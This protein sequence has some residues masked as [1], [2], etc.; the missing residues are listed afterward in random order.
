M[1]VNKA[2]L[3]YFLENNDSNPVSVEESG[4]TNLNYVLANSNSNSS[5]RIEIETEIR[6]R[7]NL[8]ERVYGLKGANP[9]SMV[10]TQ[11]KDL[12]YMVSDKY[13]LRSRDHYHYAGPGKSAHRVLRGNAKVPLVGP[14]YT[15]DNTLH[16]VEFTWD[17]SLEEFEKITGSLKPVTVIEGNRKRMHHDYLTLPGFT[18]PLVLAFDYLHTLKSPYSHFTEVSYEANMFDDIPFPEFE[19]LIRQIDAG[20]TD[21]ETM[22]DFLSSHGPSR[23]FIVDSLEASEN[24][25]KTFITGELGTNHGLIEPRIYPK[26]NM[27]LY[28]Q[29]RPEL[30]APRIYSETNTE[31]PSCQQF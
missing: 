20:G 15:A 24:T 27:D 23:K 2:D 28:E 14:G 7:E 12:Y 13:Y 26:I 8:I 5:V 1:S 3:E 16:M 21:Y 11:C 9:A 19:G 25:V 31:G 4:F 22:L 30:K 17:Y 18:V 29:K 10:E 6:S